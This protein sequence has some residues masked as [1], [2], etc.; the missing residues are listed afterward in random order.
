[1]KNLLFLLLLSISSCTSE[2]EFAE[3]VGYFKGANKGRAFTYILPTNYTQD[4]I[5]QH[6]QKQ[7]HTPGKMTT[8]F[9]YESDSNAIDP[10][11][12]NTSLYD[13]IKVLSVSD[14]KYRFD[15]TPSGKA[16]LYQK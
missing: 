9:Y 14:Y 6:A 7:M 1:M 10:T 4:Q 11:Q 5:R 2:P 12:Y 13:V 8:V 16:T 15:K 3:R